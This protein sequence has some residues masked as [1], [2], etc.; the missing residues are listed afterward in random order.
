MDKTSLQ[1]AFAKDL[2]H[3]GYI[4]V[5]LWQ[6][7]EAFPHPKRFGILEMSAMIHAA[8]EHNVPPPPEEPTQ[9]E[10]IEAWCSKHGFEQSR[11]WNKRVIEFSIPNYIPEDFRGKLKSNCQDCA[12][13]DLIAYSDAPAETRDARSFLRQWHRNDDPS[14]SY[15]GFTAA[16]EIV[17]ARFERVAVGP[18]AFVFKRTA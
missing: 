14:E 7:E 11:P 3:T 4:E 16:V 1:D 9:D 2:F 10:Q 8:I 17:T 6:I 5:D 15:R 13:G 12:I 18:R